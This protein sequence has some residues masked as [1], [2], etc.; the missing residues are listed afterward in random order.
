MLMCNFIQLMLQVQECTPSCVTVSPFIQLNSLW[1]YFRMKLCL[2]SFF[3]PRATNAENFGLSRF[4]CIIRIEY[5]IQLKFLIKL[6]SLWGSC[7]HRCMLLF[8][9][10]LGTWCQP[11]ASIFV[12]AQQ[13]RNVASVHQFHAGIPLPPSNSPSTWNSTQSPLLPLTD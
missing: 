8:R 6:T 4:L 9:P 2:F 12:T 10:A 7:E 5:S 13:K 1:L 11:G 3:T